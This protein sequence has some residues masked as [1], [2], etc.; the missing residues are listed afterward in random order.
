MQIVIDHEINRVKWIDFIMGNQYTTPFQSPEFYDFF[1]KVPNQVA[2]A[3]AIQGSR[4]LTAL[5]VVTLQR[6]KGLKG[7]FSR[8]AIIYGGPLVEINCELDLEELIRFINNY[9]RRKVIYLETR[10]F[11]DYS[12]LRSSLFKQGWTYF[13]HLDVQ[14][15]LKS[16]TVQGLVGDMKYNRKREIKLS[17]KYGASYSEADSLEEVISLYSILTELYEEKVNLPLPELEY[18]IELFHSPIGKV[19]IVRHDHHIIGGSCCIYY[20]NSSIFTLYYCG[21]RNYMRNVYPTHLA[22]M[23]AMEFGVENNLQEL[24]LM[25]AGKPG[26]EYGVRNYKSQFGGSLI[27]FGRFMIIYNHFLYKIGKLGLSLMKRKNIGGK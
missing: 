21:K 17:L 15:S 23:A 20:P 19:F 18:F 26:E 16:K 6:E 3:F 4:S 12:S 9:L 13:P 25:G 2:T 10:N 11:K 1:N 7:Y 8:R 24:D 14:I 27:E 22:I 5:C